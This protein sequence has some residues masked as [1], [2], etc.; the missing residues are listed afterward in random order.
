MPRFTA[1]RA[2]LLPA[3][4]DRDTAELQRALALGG[5]PLQS[6]I[7]G[8]Q[9]APLWHAR[10]KADAFAGHRLNAAMV[11]LGQR[12]AQL[13]IDELFARK[14]IA[15][16]VFKGGG[17]RELVYD[18]PSLRPCCD[19]DILVAPEQRSEA[20]RVLVDAG[21]RLALEPAVISHEVT[22]SKDVVAIDLHWGL[23]RP[24]RTPASLTTQ[25]LERRQQN[26][27]RWI[28]SDGDA[29]FV[30]L[31]HPAFSKHLSASQMGLHR[32]A[33]IVLWLQRRDVDWRAL[34]E[35][36]DACGLKTAAWTILSLVRLLS[37]AT[38]A[39]VVGGAIESLQP[40]RLR[41]AYL[42]SW[43]RGDL[44]ARLT[45]VHAAR[46]LGLSLWLHDQPADAWRALRGWQQSRRTRETDSLVFG[47]LDQRLRQSS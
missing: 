30:M 34:Y 28:L 17:I 41:T 12:S 11:Y 29:L 36:L 14:G 4:A 44:S 19:I 45:H 7:L 20:A 8:Q 6:L 9:L 1:A 25:M 23:L 37:P 13:E 10:T 26:R 27:G 18:D 16:A 42:N 3:F 47:G 38:F 2:A 5:A 39:P 33:D 46:L 15:Y 31:V 35:Q 24:G 21:Y 43:L 40:G 32:I 22:L